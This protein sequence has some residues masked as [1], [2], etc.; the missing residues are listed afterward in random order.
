MLPKLIE[1][2]KNLKDE[3]YDKLSSRQIVVEQALDNPDSRKDAQD[4]LRCFWINLFNFKILQKTLEIMLLRP[5]LLKKELIN[6]SMAVCFMNSIKVS[7]Q[8]E[9]LS[10]LEVFK[11]MLRHDDMHMMLGPFE[12]KQRS[13]KELPQALQ[14]LAVAEQH[15]MTCFA[16][17]M[18]IK[19]WLHFNVYDKQNFDEQLRDIFVNMQDKLQLDP[20]NFLQRIPKIFF[21]RKPE[22]ECMQTHRA[23]T[24]DKA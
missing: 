23:S 2:M 21:W 7:I 3:E 6:C 18:P 9:E 1:K 4:I 5:R 17:Y 11:T 12:E 19:K 24:L 16:L 15:P 14:D 8:G 20:Q 22:T 13:L 10:C